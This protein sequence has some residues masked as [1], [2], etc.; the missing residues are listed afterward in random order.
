MA[1]DW[2]DAAGSALGVIGDRAE[3]LARFMAHTF[4]HLPSSL[5]KLSFYGHMVSQIP[6]LSL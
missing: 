2:R 4:S 6:D 3:A 5:H 1:E